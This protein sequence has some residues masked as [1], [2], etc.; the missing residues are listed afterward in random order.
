MDIKIDGTYLADVVK[1]RRTVKP[2]KMNGKTIDNQVVEE[3]LALADWAP[4]HAR[5]EPWRFVVYSGDKV[6]AFTER[7][8]ELFR[9]NTPE[10]SFTPQ[11][12]EK[13]KALSENVSHIIVVWMKR[14]PNHK[15]PEIEE[16]AATA[17]AIQTLL[18]AATAN[19]I[20]TFWSTG[21]LTHHPAMRAELGLG[22]EDRV[23]GI[24]YMG[25]SDEEP[26]EGSR[27]IPV[28]EKT[29]WIQ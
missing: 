14:V 27:S 12:Y 18:L 5:T 9:E 29:Q 28:T 3:L 10:A 22:E 1:T 7:H 24:L 19:G 13:I 20:A 23:M 11:K 8:A 6:G 21:G 15:I 16:V 25:Y 4:T 26:R 2:E 17:A